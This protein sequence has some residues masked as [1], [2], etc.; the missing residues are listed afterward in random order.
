M[1]ADNFFSRWGKAKPATD[2]SGQDEPLAAQDPQK[3]QNIR[4]PDSGDSES[5]A[6]SLPPPTL[7]E[8]ARLTPDS[9]F[10]RFVGKD[11]DETVKRSAMKK[12]FSNPH[13]NV[14][15]R[16]DVYIDDYNQFTPL[17]ATMLASLNHAKDLLKPL[18]KQEETETADAE[19]RMPPA[20]KTA[21]P[22]DETAETTS[23]ENGE[24][25]TVENNGSGGD[26][27]TQESNSF[28]IKTDKQAS[29]AG[30]EDQHLSRGG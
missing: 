15:D 1:A 11:V 29:A 6:E 3:L 10:S 20:E 26:M 5:A 30:G 12:L 9:D 23:T 18:R 16:L 24:S 7:D 4:S 14:M 8:V 28:D 25:P 22:D 13:F 19:G 17:T 27:L 2:V 21:M